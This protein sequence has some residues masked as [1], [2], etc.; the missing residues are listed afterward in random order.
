MT[1]TLIVAAAALACWILDSLY[2]PLADCWW[3]SGSSKR[4]RE[5]GKGKRKSFHLCLVCGGSGRRRRFWSSV[6]QRGLG[7]L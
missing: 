6:L 7:K 3:C 2:D 4:R 5:N 1:T